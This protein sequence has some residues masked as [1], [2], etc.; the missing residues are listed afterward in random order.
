VPLHCGEA[1][2]AL[3]AATRRLHDHGRR[4]VIGRARTLATLSRAP[5]EHVARH[6]VALHQNLRELRASARR[7]VGAER[8]L[9]ATHALVVSRKA[10]ATLVDCRERRPRELE[11]LALTLSAHHPERTLERG[12]ALVE[13]GDGALVTSASAAREAGDVRLRFADGTVGARIEE[14]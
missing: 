7:R 8:A 9:T 12:Y 14:K 10:Q 5:A 13:R 4:A 1:R 2:G 3:A 6:R 11:R